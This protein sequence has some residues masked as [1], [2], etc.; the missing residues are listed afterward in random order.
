MPKCLAAPYPARIVAVAAATF[1]GDRRTAALEIREYADSSGAA[2][3][4]KTEN[5]LERHR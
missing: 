5:V 1:G 2:S 4:E 3:A